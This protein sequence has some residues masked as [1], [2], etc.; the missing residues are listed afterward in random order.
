[1]GA[2]RRGWV[3]GPVVALTVVLGLAATVPPAGAAITDRDFPSAAAVRSAMDGV[4]RW[5]AAYDGDTRTLGARPADCRSDL[6]M[7]AFR[8]DR[9]RWYHGRQAGTASSVHAQVHTAVHRYA[10][11]ADAR[12]A[13][14]RNATYPRR[15]PRVT[16]WT[17]TECD[18]ITTTWRDRV[19][20][21]RVG[22]ESIA[23]R[24]RAVDN[25][26]SNGYTVVARSGATLVRT[27]VS[28]YRVPDGGAFTAPR[29]IA[30]DKAVRL[31]RMSLRAALPG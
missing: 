15:C 25:F 13:L 1:M 26:K 30:K 29:L 5:T 14:T 21:P 16:E 27:T 31:A 22:R 28:R 8:E 24:F 17:C 6:Q 9:A 4:G 2:G 18:G 10:S 3:R 23:W 20:A 19:A 7:L 12:A 11:V